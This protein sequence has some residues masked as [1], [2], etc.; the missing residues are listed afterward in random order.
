MEVI[1]VTYLKYGT[2]NDKLEMFLSQD[3]YYYYYCNN[4][5]IYIHNYTI[6][7]IYKKHY[8]KILLMNIYI[9]YKNS[10]YYKLRNV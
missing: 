10:N 8:K 4:N 5:I 2:K 9:N 1:E 7:S 6:D 3:L